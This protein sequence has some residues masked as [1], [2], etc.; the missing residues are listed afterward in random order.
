MTLVEVTPIE[1]RRSRVGKEFSDWSSPVVTM[2]TGLASGP[3]RLLPGALVLVTTERWGRGRL[4]ARGGGG[5]GG[6]GDVPLV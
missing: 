5:G 2:D 6:G 1:S 3:M 4:K